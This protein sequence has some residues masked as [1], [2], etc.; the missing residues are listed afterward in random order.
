VALPLAVA[1]FG[2]QSVRGSE[3]SQNDALRSFFTGGSSIQFNWEERDFTPAPATSESNFANTLQGFGFN[4]GGGEPETLKGVSFIDPNTGEERWMDPKWKDIAQG[5]SFSGHLIPL[6][7]GGMY[8]TLA[9]R[10]VS[11][12]EIRQWEIN[13]TVSKV[14]TSE[15]QTLS[16][17]LDA[18]NSGGIT[19]RPGGNIGSFQVGD[20]TFTPQPGSAAARRFSATSGGSANSGENF[21]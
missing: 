10:W 20:T 8:D 16:A 12:E 15:S 11:P 19:P 13:R 5:G 17:A 3:S 1:Y 6:I 7:S 18:V 9:M 2:S 14:Q 4:V 21:K